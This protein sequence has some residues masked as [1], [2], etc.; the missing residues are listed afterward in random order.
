MVKAI[1]GPTLGP[2]SFG[3][4]IGRRIHQ[5]DKN[6][7]IANFPIVVT[8]EFFISDVIVSK[9]GHEQRYLYMIYQF[10][11]H[12]PENVYLRRFIESN[13]IGSLSLAR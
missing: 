11:I 5:V 7:P 8:Q 4:V 9:L 12:G 10:L 6:W 1:I 13:S 3:G 2:E